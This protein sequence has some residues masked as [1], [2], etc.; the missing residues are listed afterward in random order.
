MPNPLTFG[1]LFA[2]A[3]ILAGLIALAAAFTWY[4]NSG[5]PRGT[6][7]YARAR[8]GRRLTILAGALALLLVAVGCLTPLCSIP[9]TGGAG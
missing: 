7:L 5:H 6:P 1:H 8:D 9:L 2:L 4:R 3:A